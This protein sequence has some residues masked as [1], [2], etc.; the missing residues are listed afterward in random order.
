MKRK[1]LLTVSALLTLIGNSKAFPSEGAMAMPQSGEG[2]EEIVVTMYAL[3]PDGAI[4]W[5]SPPEPLCQV[6]DTR[7]G[8]TAFVDDE[9]HTYPYPTNPVMVPIENEL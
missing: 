4:N 6:E 3:T 2:F 9:T 8:C 5:D 7:Y 1:I